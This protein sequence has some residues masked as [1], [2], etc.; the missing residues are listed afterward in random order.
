MY[1]FQFSKIVFLAEKFILHLDK[2]CSISADTDTT[3]INDMNATQVPNDSSESE[4]DLNSKK[5]L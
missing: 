1:I 4:E 5:L 3:L 2:A